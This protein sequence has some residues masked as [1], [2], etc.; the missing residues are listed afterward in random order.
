MFVK[1]RSTTAAQ[2][3]DIREIRPNLMRAIHEEVQ[4]DYAWRNIIFDHD[5]YTFMNEHSNL[6]DTIPIDHEDADKNHEDNDVE[7]DD[8]HKKK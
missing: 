8:N 2:L 7:D 5:N 3:T 6:G 4:N 1:H